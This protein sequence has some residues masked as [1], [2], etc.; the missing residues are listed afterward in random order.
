MFEREQ[1]QIDDEVKIVLGLDTI[2]LV[3]PEVDGLE[4]TFNAAKEKFNLPAIRIE[5]DN[6]VGC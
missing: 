1:E 4:R 5:Q 6:L 3:R 2:W